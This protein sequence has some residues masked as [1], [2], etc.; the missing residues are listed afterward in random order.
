MR[1][2]IAQGRRGQI[3]GA[4]VFVVLIPA[5]GA[6]PAAKAQ[7]AQAAEARPNQP[8]AGQITRPASTQGTRPAAATAELESLDDLL[9]PVREQYQ[10]PALAAAFVRPDGVVAAGAVGVRKAGGNEPV[11]LDDRF[12]IGSCTKAMTATLIGLLVEEGQLDWD[13][14]LG[15]VF[16]DQNDVVRTEYQDVTLRQLL[17]HRSGLPDD[18]APDAVFLKL[19]ALQ[20]PIQEQ[21][22][23][24]VELVLSRPPA[25]APGTQMAY[26][27]AGYA[28]LGAAAER[29]TGRAWEDLLRERVFEPLGMTTAGFGAPGTV[30]SADQPW[31]HRGRIANPVPV[32]PGPFADNPAVIGPAGT[33]HCGVLD[34]A[35]FVQLHLRGAC[36]QAVSAS[37]DGAKLRLKRETFDVLHGDPY[38]QGYAMGWG[39]VERDWASGRALTHAGSN[40]MWFAVV[41]I[42]PRREAALI[43]ACNYG[44][45]E[46]FQA[47]DAAIA[48]MIERYLK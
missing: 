22:R 46:G 33:V 14:A 21:R 37:H 18:R 16:A 42:A 3:G 38:G 34:W 20:G 9:K 24:M 32:E 48:A 15:K 35:K 43:A 10:V 7:A 31:G 26:S 36:G 4:L 8:A 44:G 6:F 19:R 40:T 30:G 47:C 13:T 23:R 39:V 1:T 27:N 11:T 25:A 41:W 5:F 12:H 17:L 28:L 2:A 29:A 45:R